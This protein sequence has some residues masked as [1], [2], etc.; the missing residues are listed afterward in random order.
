MP[1]RTFRVALVC[2]CVLTVIGCAPQPG[3]EVAPV[4]ATP[5]NLPEGFYRSASAKGEP[6]FMIDSS[7][8]QSVLIRVYREGPLSRLGHDH[9]VAARQVRGYVLVPRDHAQARTDLYLSVGSLLVDDAR[10]RA[11]AGFTTRIT[12]ADIEGTRR[13]MLDA[14]LESAQFPFVILSG[15]C[16]SD[17][18]LCGTLDTRITLHGVT[19]TISVPIVVQS[20]SARLVV[21]GH[22]SVLLTDF[23]MT[24]YSVLGGAL[25]V[26]D[27]VD[28][29]FRL[30]ARPM[31]AN[32]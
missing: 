20:D 17:M 27:R 4:P 3:R 6:V 5:A 1:L 7:K 11:E 24:P 14:V 2:L 18:P 31:R 26:S 15:V 16:V 22:L 28:V 10:D 19:R 13:H 25:R 30:E 32:S 21:S 12:Q 23:G 29:D 8:P 9:V